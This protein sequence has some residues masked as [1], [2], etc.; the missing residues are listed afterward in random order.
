MRLLPRTSR[1]RASRSCAAAISLSRS[2]RL[3]ADGELA[4]EDPDVDRLAHAL[5]SSDFKRVI[6]ASTR[7]RA[8]SFLFSSCARSF[9]QLFLALAQ[10][11]VFLG[12]AA[13]AGRAAC[14][15]GRPVAASGPGCRWNPSPHDRQRAAAGST[16][17]SALDDRRGRRR[18]SGRQL[19]MNARQRSPSSGGDSQWP[20]ISSQPCSRRKF[21][22]SSV[23]TP[24]AI[25]FRPSEWPMVMM[26]EVIAS[27]SG[28]RVRSSMNS[29]SIFSVSIG[30]RLR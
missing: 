6:I 4:I 8:S 23:S 18:R 3:A 27:S 30:R 25:T 2:L 17:T 28:S 11:A 21:S 10:A 26:V 24:S 20:W 22:W 5:F 13:G 16:A 29:L 1:M 14:R 7:D 15:C 12:Q 9:D 19:R